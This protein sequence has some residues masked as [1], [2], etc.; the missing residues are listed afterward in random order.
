MLQNFAARV[1]LDIVSANTTGAT[2]FSKVSGTFVNSPGTPWTS[3]TIP[4]N[5][6][7]AVKGGTCAVWYSGPKLTADSFTGGTVVLISGSNP[8]DELCLVFIMYDKTNG[9]FTV[10]IQ[11][12]ATGNSGEPT[13]PTATA[14]TISVSNPV[15]NPS[16]TAPTITVED[17]AP[18]AT[19]GIETHGGL[20]TDM[21]TSD[22]NFSVDWNSDVDISFKVRQ[23]GVAWSGSEDYV[24]TCGSANVNTNGY[25]GLRTRSANAVTFQSRDDVGLN[26]IVDPVTISPDKLIRI[27]KNAT[28]LELLIDG[29]S[30]GTQALGGMTLGSKAIRFGSNRDDN[31]GTNYAAVIIY[32][33]NINGETWDFAEQTGTTATGSLGSVLTLKPGTKTTADM[34]VEIV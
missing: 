11:D 1:G 23:G 18:S 2:N 34:W 9:S 25:V 17:P 4:L 27:T 22:G 13:T 31:G 26:N 14:P 3:G 16:A 32:D 10:N 29:V 5:K 30:Q 15:A 6:T 21:F 12:G 19:Y 20:D 7:G 24:M 8:V 28:Q 33:L